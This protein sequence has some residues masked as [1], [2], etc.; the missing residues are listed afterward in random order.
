MQCVKVKHHVNQVECAEPK[1]DH[2]FLMSL[3]HHCSTSHIGMFRYGMF[4][5]R[6][7]DPS[8]YTLCIFINDATEQS[9]YKRQC[10]AAEQQFLRTLAVPHHTCA[11]TQQRP[12]KFQHIYNCILRTNSAAQTGWTVWSSAKFE[13]PQ[14]RPWRL[15]FSELLNSIA[16]SQYSWF[17]GTNKTI[18]NIRIN[19]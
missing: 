10:Q 7:A 8:R 1:E 6:M 18:T 13:S 17:V 9:T 4:S 5:W 14:Q 2:I 3:S 12:N 15:L 16:W 11:R 19:C